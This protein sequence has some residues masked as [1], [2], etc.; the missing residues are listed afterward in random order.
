M[1]LEQ[2]IK[3][4][5]ETMRELIAALG[6]SG[7]KANAGKAGDDEGTKTTTTR[8]RRTT[9]T[10]DDK[11][12]SKYTAEQVKTI[13]VKVKDELGT[14]AAKELIGKYAPELAKIKPADFDAF[15]A[16]CETAL[17]PDAGGN[18]NDDDDGGL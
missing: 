4:N 17:D 10:D 8:T 2:A 3:E 12:G 6:A 15:V 16:D 14:K 5:T 1:S 7:G 13:A 11:G 9:K 18:G